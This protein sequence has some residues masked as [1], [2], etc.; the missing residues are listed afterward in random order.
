MSMTSGFVTTNLLFRGD[1]WPACP[2]LRKSA[3]DLLP[4]FNRLRFCSFS[5]DFFISDAL[6]GMII[7]LSLSALREKAGTLAALRHA[8][9]ARTIEAEEGGRFNAGILGAE[10]PIQHINISSQKHISKVLPEER[11]CDRMPFCIS[12]IDPGRLKGEEVVGL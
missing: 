7:V 9:S 2:L 12:A 8:S 10:S 3:V 6:S 11:I 5:L 4:R 1:V